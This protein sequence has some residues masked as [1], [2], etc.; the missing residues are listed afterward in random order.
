MARYQL[1]QDGE[2]T[3]VRKTTRAEVDQ[4][5]EDNIRACGLDWRVGYLIKFRN[6]DA[7]YEWV[8]IKDGARLQPSR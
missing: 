4:W 2:A 6:S 7:T 1:L 8:R 5:M 3:Q